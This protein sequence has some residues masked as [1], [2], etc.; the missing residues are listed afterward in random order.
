MDEVSI[1]SIIEDIAS[2]SSNIHKKEVLHKHIDNELFKRVLYLTYSPRVTF[3]MKKLKS[4][5]INNELSMTLNDALDGLENIADRMYTGNEA[6]D[7]LSDILCSLTEDDAEVV[8]RI[9]GRDLRCGINAKTISSEIPDLLEQTPYMGAV[10]FNEKKARKIFAAGGSAY[11][12]VKYDGRYV[13]MVVRTYSYPREPFEMTSRQGKPSMVP[14]KQLKND[15]F[16]LALSLMHVFEDY[17]YTGIVL[18]GEL[19]MNDV[20]RY[21][22][23]GIIASIVSIHEKEL[24]HGTPLKKD[25]EKFHKEHDMTYEEAVERVYMVV[26]DFLPYEVY[27]HT[28]TFDMPRVRRISYLDHSFNTSKVISDSQRIKLTEYTLVHSYEEAIAHFNK[29]VARGEEGTI[30]KSMNGVWKNGK[31]TYQIKMKLEMTVDMVVKGFNEGNGKYEGML[32]SLITESVDGLVHADPYA[33]KDDERIE[34]WN[35]K[36]KYLNSVV[37]VKCNGLSNDR[38]GNYSLLHPVFK[39]FRDDTTPDTLEDIKNNQD[40]IMGLKNV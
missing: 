6:L 23:N 38:D 11:S 25:R 26:W 5:T 32:G 27:I 35:N 39:S 37:E 29:M 34:I 40:M 24:K 19:L 13:N 15:G 33:F 17:D 10:S 28:Q 4:Y 36:D 12:E 14:S 31:P 16:N 22:S 21:K 8:K 9:I 20:S 30:L 18:N 3:Y 1:L 7:Y 2:N